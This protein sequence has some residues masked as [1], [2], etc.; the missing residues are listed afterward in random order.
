M[1]LA[2]EAQAELIKIAAIGVA[3]V[4][5]VVVVGRASG[6]AAT[7][8][9]QA[10]NEAVDSVV[11]RSNEA[12]MDFDLAG[13]VVATTPAASIGQQT[14]PRLETASG[15]AGI[16]FTLDTALSSLTAWLRGAR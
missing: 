5:A 10:V 4:V 16:L 2:G 14:G 7:A 11:A 1:Q 15:P 12:W 9:G 3:V 13:A 6:K 8:I